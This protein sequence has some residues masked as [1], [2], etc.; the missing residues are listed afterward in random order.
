MWKRITQSIS[1]ILSHDQAKENGV[2][3]EPQ[4]RP[5]LLDRFLDEYPRVTNRTADTWSVNATQCAAGV[6]I[7]QSPSDVHIEVL[8]VAWK[9]LASD[10]TIAHEDKDSYSEILRAILACPLPLSESDCVELLSHLVLDYEHHESRSF[11]FGSYGSHAIDGLMD[12]L[13]QRH[14]VEGLSNE[15]IAVLKRLTGSR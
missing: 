10:Y 12:Q 7:L 6:A 3:T 2:S 9:S 14:A 5:T 8:K 4:H 13:I 11:F 1:T 15:V